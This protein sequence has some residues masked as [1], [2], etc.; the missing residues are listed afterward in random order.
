MWFIAICG[1]GYLANSI[2][3]SIEIT[4]ITFIILCYIAITKNKEKM[5][6]D[7]NTFGSKKF[8][9]IILFVYMT[10]IIIILKIMG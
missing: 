8:I 4:Q 1:S 7:N 5:K 6:L 3:I 2:D 10:N 9:T